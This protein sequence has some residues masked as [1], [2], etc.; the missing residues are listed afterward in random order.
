[1]G[2]LSNAASLGKTKYPELTALSFLVSRP[3][4]ALFFFPYPTST[5]ALSF[6][7]GWEPTVLGEPIDAIL[8]TDLVDEHE[9]IRL[10][11]DVPDPL[12]S[13][14]SLVPGNERLTDSVSTGP[15]AWER[16]KVI[17]AR[18]DQ[19]A[20]SIRHST[21][22]GDML[23]CRMFSRETRFDPEYDWAGREFVRYP[24][25]GPLIDMPEVAH[26]LYRHGFLTRHFF[27]RIHVCPDCGS[28]RISVREECYTCRSPDTHEKPTI[29]HYM[30]GILHLNRSFAPA[31][32]LSAR[33]AGLDCAIS[34]W[35]TTSRDLCCAVMPAAA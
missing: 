17:R 24:A 30:C 6:P 22:V 19:I 28:A 3:D 21:S 26:Q 15:A 18:A 12:V 7:A 27:D 14:I 5:K 35:I 16:A 34:D 13:V 25:A 2:N 20:G 33:N 8:L 29:N 32:D 11:N 23:L 9:L 1:M 10:L 4:A 31:A